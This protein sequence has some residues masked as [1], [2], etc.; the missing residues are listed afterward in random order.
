[1]KTEEDLTRV[2]WESN[3]Q[4]HTPSPGLQAAEETTLPPGWTGTVAGWLDSIGTDKRPFANVA[5]A[6]VFSSKTS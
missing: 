1:M 4:H 6:K 3:K 2:C 5:I